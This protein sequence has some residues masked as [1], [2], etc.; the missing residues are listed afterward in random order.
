MR[1]IQD[2]PKVFIANKSSHD[3]S[4]SSTYGE[5]V[6]VTLGTIERYSVANMARAWASTLLKHE[7]VASDFILITSL[8]ILNCIG[9][10][11]FAFRHGQLNLLLYRNGRYIQRTIL[12]K[13]AFD[14]EAEQTQTE[15]VM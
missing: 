13:A 14:A 12:L 1:T 9:C 4:P 6:F 10:A 15:E 3:F 2:P 8:T 7:S 5:S 11:L